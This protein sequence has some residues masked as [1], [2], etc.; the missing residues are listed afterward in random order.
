MADLGRSFFQ[1]RPDGAEALVDAVRPRLD[2]PAAGGHLVDLYGGVGL[3]AGTL[4]AG[5]PVTLVEQSASSA[6]DARLNLPRASTPA[7]CGPTSTTGAPARRR[8]RRRPPAHRPG[9]QGRRRRSRPPTPPG[10]PGELR[11]GGPRRDAGLLG[12]AGLR[13]RLLPL[14]DLFPH[15]S[16]VEVVSRFDR[17]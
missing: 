15:T 5:G 16:H 14:V 2:G 3:F 12:E 6:A 4:V 8:G 17:R 9:G 11:P 1:A 13:P 10:G 7:S